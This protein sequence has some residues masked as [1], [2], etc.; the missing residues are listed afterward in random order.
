MGCRRGRDAEGDAG[1]K[2]NRNMQVIP[3]RDDSDSLR[4]FTLPQLVHQ[5]VDLG[6]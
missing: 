2:E 5:S 3:R 1:V 6:A 4:C